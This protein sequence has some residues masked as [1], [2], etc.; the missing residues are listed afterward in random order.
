MRRNCI[1]PAVCGR[2][3]GSADERGCPR[4]SGNTSA[5]VGEYPQT[6]CGCDSA[7]FHTARCSQPGGGER[8]DGLWARS[9][10]PTSQPLQWWRCWCWCWWVAPCPLAQVT[11]TS[12]VM[13]PLAHD[14]WVQPVIILSSRQRFSRLWGCS[15]LSCCYF[16]RRDRRILFSVFVIVN[17]RKD[18][19]RLL[20]PVCGPV[21]THLFLLKL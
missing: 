6:V 7:V 11:A 20:C 10:C 16:I 3:S 1:L 19:T 13:Q 9:L 5:H 17:N 14:A 18:Q 12:R 8:P 21:M 15:V 4:R 2:R